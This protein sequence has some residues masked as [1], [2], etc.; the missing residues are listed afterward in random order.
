MHAKFHNNS[1]DKI[2]L[3]SKKKFGWHEMS[4]IKKE[5]FFLALKVYEKEWG[6]FIK[7][8]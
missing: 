5:S 6:I 1:I 3:I 4:W 8:T 2:E 7:V